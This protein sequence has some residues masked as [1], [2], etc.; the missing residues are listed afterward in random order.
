VHLVAQLPQYFDEPQGVYTAAGPCYSNYY[1]HKDKPFFRR[2][3]FIP[4]YRQD[5]YRSNN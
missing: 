4:L 5:K 2:D 3:L 1:F